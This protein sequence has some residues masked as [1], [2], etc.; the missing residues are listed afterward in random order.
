LQRHR[1][2]ELKARTHPSTA[3]EHTFVYP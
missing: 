1:V 2:P 3:P